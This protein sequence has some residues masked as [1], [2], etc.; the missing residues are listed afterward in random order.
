MLSVNPADGA[1]LSVLYGTDAM[2]AVIG[3]RAFIGQM[4]AVEAALARAQARLG[5]IPEEAATAI[6]E[7]ASIEKLD[8]PALARATR[9]TG[10]PVVGLVKQLSLLAGTEAGRWTH[11]G[12]TTQDIMDTAIVLQLREAFAL[13]GADLDRLNQA[14][15]RQAREHRG[16]VMAGRTHLQHALPVTF[17][18]KCAIWLSP[19][20]TMRERLDQ[21]LPRLLKVQFGGAAGTLASLGGRGL[22]VAEALAEELGLAMPDAPWHVA[23]DTM[24]EAV[25]FLGLLTGALSKLA[26]DVML[27]MQSEVAEVFEPHAP[28]RGGSSTM[29]QKRNPI[30]CEYVLAQ[31]RGVHALVP[32]M[33]GAM[34]VDQERGTGPWQAE[35]LALPQAFTLAHGALAQA[36]TIA[37]GLTV[38]GAR[39]RRNL[40]ASGGL[41]MAEAVM[42]ALA[43]LI[44]RG[45]AHDAVHHACDVALADS[46]PLAEALRRDECISAALDEAAIA[47]LTEPANYLGATDAFID[48]VLQ[49]LDP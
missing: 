27:L 9:N 10:Y 1:V 47:R 22:E 25:C 24:A 34:A 38:D 11:W 33:L 46:I 49:R 48:R 36:V 18:Y 14:L 43:E 39:M 12:A 41:I 16:L 8:L 6:A 21:L 37:E 42:M 13:L 15:A 35:P 4:L 5:I 40:D 20:I 32:Q 31:A 17:G 23:R 45:T 26:T 44:G 3:E 29:P 28:G 7:V 19:L 30:A 2:R